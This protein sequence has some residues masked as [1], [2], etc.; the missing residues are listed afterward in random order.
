MMEDLA[1]IK[2]EFASKRAAEYRSRGYEV[3]QDAPLDFMPGFRADLLVRKNGE[4]RVIAVQTRT[5]LAVTPAL[6][7]L[8]EAISAMPGWSFDL[9]LVSEP[10][11]L[12]APESAESFDPAGIDRRIV[13]AERSLAE[14]FAEAAFVLAWSAAE[15]AIRSLAAAAGVDIRRVTQSRYLL[16]H[17]VHQDAISQRDYERLSEMLAYRNAIVHGFAARGFDAQQVHDLIAVV[18][19]LQRTAAAE[20]QGQV[21]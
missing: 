13:E 1:I 3:L 8:A 9:Q 4:T 11:R 7:E 16:R 5:G 19:K 10:E 20:N 17:A 21:V 15:A 18:R 12:D 2:K 14:G 6:E